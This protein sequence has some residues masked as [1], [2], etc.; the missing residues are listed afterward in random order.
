MDPDEAVAY[1]EARQRYLAFARMSGID[2]RQPDGWAKFLAAASRDPRGRAALRDHRTQQRL[3]RASRAKLRALWRLL[4]E[5]PGERTI[6]FTDDNDTAYAIGRQFVLPVLTHHTK[7]GER[8]R[9]L[10][11]FRAGR[12]PVLVTSKV[13]NEGVDVPEATVGVVV[14]G[15]GSVREHVQRLG[16][17]L[18]PSAG[19]VAILYE[20]VST[21][22]AENFTSERRR[23][24]AAFGE[25]DL[26]GIGGPAAPAGGV[27]ADP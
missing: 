6:I 3:A 9:M 12:W 27:H 8:R 10:D 14:S 25:E 2:W 18:R 17:I 19:K 16:R 1:A 24:H 23:G 15:S 26:F 22:T 11:R 7:P 21:G 13:L 20:L 4:S 5:H